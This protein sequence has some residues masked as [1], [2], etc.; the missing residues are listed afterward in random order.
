MWLFL[1]KMIGGAGVYKTM[2]SF[3]LPSFLLHLS[4]FSLQPSVTPK[5][6]QATVFSFP[7]F[8]LFLPHSIPISIPSLPLHVSLH[9]TSVW[10]AGVDSELACCQAY[11]AGLCS[12]TGLERTREAKA[13]PLHHPH[14]DWL[15]SERGSV[16]AHERL[17]W[18]G[19]YAFNTGT[20]VEHRPWALTP[21]V[22]FLCPPHWLKPAVLYRAM[23]SWLLV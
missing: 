14:Q 13:G 18:P 2:Y 5:L 16:H 17:A 4:L 15:G 19:P 12:C 22:P 9:P 1:Y 20:D 7:S 10:G 23:P 8:S 6:L 21:L 3:T 11:F